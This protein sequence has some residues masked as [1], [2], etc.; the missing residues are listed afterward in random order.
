MSLQLPIV[1]QENHQ[2]NIP[3]S[4]ANSL[5]MQI[6]EVRQSLQIELNKM[7]QKMVTLTDRMNTFEIT[8]KK[9]C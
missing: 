4:N 5:Q 9:S 1:V 2:R 8:N 6:D 3:E 7:T